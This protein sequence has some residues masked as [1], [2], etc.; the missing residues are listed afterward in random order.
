[1]SLFFKFF[2]H[3]NK[4]TKRKLKVNKNKNKTREKRCQDEREVALLP[5]EEED[6]REK[7]IE[8]RDIEEKEEVLAEN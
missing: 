2:N 6:I 4:K 1:L 3:K 8:V 5:V 7:V